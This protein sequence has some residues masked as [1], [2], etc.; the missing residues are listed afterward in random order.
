MRLTPFFRTF[1]LGGGTLVAF[2]AVA[3]LIM[4]ADSYSTKHDTSLS[5]AASSGVLSND[6]GATAAVLITDSVDHGSLSLFADGHFNYTPNTGYFGLD[7]FTYRA[8]DG[9]VFGE[10][11]VTLNVT[12]LLP[13]AMPDSYS[14][15]HDTVLSVTAANGVLSNDTDGDDLLNVV[16]ITD[17]V[18]HGSLSL[19]ADGHFKYTPNAGYAGSDSF[20]YRISDGAATSTARVDL[21]VTNLL[22]QAIND[23]YTYLAGVPLDVDALTGVLWNDTD[24][25]DLLNVV[26]ITD[27]VDHGSLSLFA[28]GHFKYTP[29]VGYTGDDSFMYRISDGAAT[30]SARVTLSTRATP[31]PIPEPGTLFLLLAAGLT[32]AACRSRR[33]KAPSQTT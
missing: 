5:V 28:D 27:P 7:S 25:D 11:I 4:G 8:T 23:F 22:P 10:A 18:D 29:N 26:L 6:T 14:I 30:A 21:A 20:E 15:K 33:F 13:L 19:F 9:T 31:E 3:A 1:I 17:P 2:P 12:N 16:L 24:G 32:G